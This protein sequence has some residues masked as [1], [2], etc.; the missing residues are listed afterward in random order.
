[1]T[2]ADAQ[3]GIC[4]FMCHQQ[5][6]CRSTNYDHTKI[7]QDMECI[8]FLQI[9][10]DK[11]ILTYL[12][13]KL[14]TDSLIKVLSRIGSTQMVKEAWSGTQM[15]PR[16]MNA[17]VPGRTDAAQEEDLASVLGS[18]SPCSWQKYMPLRHAHWRIQKRAT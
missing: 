11:I 17:L 1:M 16:P 12:Y 18:T 4:R 13:H 7:F 10:T 15:G 6:R 3:V 9:V 2:E 14:F 5:W 8:P